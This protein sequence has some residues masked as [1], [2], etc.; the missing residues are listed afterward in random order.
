MTSI[1]GTLPLLRRMIRPIST[2]STRNLR[3]E[4]G[5]PPVGPDN[6][7]LSNAADVQRQNLER[8]LQAQLKDGGRSKDVKRLSDPLVRHLLRVSGNQS[9]R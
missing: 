9:Y 2:N 1:K 5:I 4:P 7:V 3:L 6:A 8:R